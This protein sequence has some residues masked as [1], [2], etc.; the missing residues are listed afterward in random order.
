MLD[1]EKQKISSEVLNNV[2]LTLRLANIEPTK[3]NI[4][5][6][7]SCFIEGIKFFKERQYEK[8]N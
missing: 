1:E 5:I 3:Q 6:G 8:A 4:L 7:L 2:V